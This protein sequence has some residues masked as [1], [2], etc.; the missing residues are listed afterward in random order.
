MKKMIIWGLG[1]IV[2]LLAI[3]FSIMI[4]FMFLGNPGSSGGTTGEIVPSETQQ[5][6]IDAV[7]PIAQETYKEYGVFPSI[8]LAQAILESAWGKSGLSIQANN[9]F[10]IKADPSW[11]G[12]ILEL[13]TQEHVNGGIITIIARWRVY[14]TW[15][16]S[17]K[18]HGQF[19]KENSR[20]TEAGVF[21]SKSYIEQANTL[22]MAGYATDPSYAIL[23]CNLIESYGL[24]KYD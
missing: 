13:P 15:Q 4:F 3:P 10:G 16:G 23:L 21:N 11:Q 2:S 7:A 17:I 8:T 9:L 6:F 22:Q 1:G 12:E 14:E 20:Y 24:Q 18:D 5:A 19:L